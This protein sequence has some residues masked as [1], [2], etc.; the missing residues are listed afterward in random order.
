MDDR[1]I[2]ALHELLNDGGKGPGPKAEALEALAHH[3]RRVLGSPHARRGLVAGVVVGTVVA[4]V[5]V[6]VAWSHNPQQSI[7]GSSGIAWVYLAALALGWFVLSGL[8]TTALVSTFS[9][10]FGRTRSPAA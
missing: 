8:V 1:G 7:H 6:I 9:L 3:A 4:A 2:S 10:V 5:M